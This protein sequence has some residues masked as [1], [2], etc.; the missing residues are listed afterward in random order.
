[1]SY[2]LRICIVSTI[3]AIA[4]AVAAT[5]M[6]SKAT[7][8]GSLTS[9]AAAD[10]VD[11]GTLR[12]AARS[13]V[14][15]GHQSV[16]GN[17]IEGISPA[18]EADGLASP[19]IV[20]LSPGSSMRLPSGGFFA[21]SFIGVNGDPEGKVDE[22]DSMLRAGLGEEVSVAMMKFCYIDIT[23]STDLAG[24]FRKYQATFAALEGDYPRIS[25][26]H[27]TTPLTTSPGLKS[28]VKSA[29]G[30]G[31][32]NAAD[33]AARARLNTMIRETFP[34]DRL[35]DLAALESTAPDGGRVSG[36]HEGNKYDTLYSGYAVDEGHLTPTFSRF[37]ASKMLAVVA[38]ASV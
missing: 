37:A 22:F 16:G 32:P 9:K 26:L 36:S 14:F 23:A 17:M 33:N 6:T 31:N 13:R 5:V 15:F 4:L 1:M 38:D 35:F 29:L 25:F 20:E 34:G 7:G 3:T 24:L 19:K 11:G 10:A 21:H 12:T 27:I 8:H 18:Y 30:A 2:K 28:R